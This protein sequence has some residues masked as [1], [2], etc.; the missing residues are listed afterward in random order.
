MQPTL[1]GSAEPLR[2][3]ES[4]GP[5]RALIIAGPTASGKSA[6]ALQLAERFGGTIINADAMQCYRELRVVTARPPPEDEARAPH[7]L[8]GVLPAATPGSVAWWREAALVQMAQARLPIL[9]GGTGMYLRAL[10]QGLSMLP[11]IPPEAREAARARLA[12]LGAA[13]LH[14]ELHPEDAARLRPSDSQRIARALEVFLATGQSLATWHR[15]APRLPPADYDF[16]AILLTP[17]RAE[18]HPAIVARWAMM[19]GQGA[20]AEVGALL[21]QGLDP[22]LPAMRAHGVPE[23]AAEWRGEIG[24]AEADARSIGGTWTYTRR[25]ATWFRHQ[26]LV[27]PTATHRINARIAGLT[28]FSERN[29]PEIFAFLQGAG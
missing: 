27:A 10:I 2:G 6:L 18:L 5:R 9:C 20:L 13:R 22:N 23:L 21:E 4:D 8:Y 12:T 26:H 25:Q 1:I 11:G 24:M 16:R 15:M 7:V 28:Q 29:A 3:R 17:P 19:R 14:A